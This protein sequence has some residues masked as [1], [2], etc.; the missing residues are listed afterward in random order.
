MASS[1]HMLG[2]AS[3][4]EYEDA[5]LEKL[6]PLLD[7]AV[8][9][10]AEAGTPLPEPGVLAHTLMS[11]LPTATTMSAYD[12]LIGPFYSSAGVMRLLRVPSKQALADRRT[13]GTLLAAQTSD[14]AW[15]YPAFQFDA[16]AHA[17][18]PE[19]VPVL[20]EL[21]T[22]PR[23]GA[24]LWLVTEHPDLDSHRPVDAAKA[25]PSVRD[26]VCALAAEYRQA[27]AA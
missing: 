13:R 22:A 16:T 5:V 23:W 21:K 1:L 4:A 8:A 12:A 20:A 3:E 11:A 10:L 14:G 18:R 6:R 26:R 25:S 27:H 19:L 15:L 24:A 7:E 17:V 2:Y 9:G